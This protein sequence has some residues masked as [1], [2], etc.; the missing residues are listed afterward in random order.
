MATPGAVRSTAPTLENAATKSAPSCPYGPRRSPGSSADGGK[1]P[2]RPRAETA[3]TSARSAGKLTGPRPSLPAAAT[4]TTPASCGLLDGGAH[5]PD[6]ASP[7]PR[8]RLTM[9]HPSATAASRAFAIAKLVASAAAAAEDPV[10]AAARPRERRPAARRWAAS[11][12]DDA[13]HVGAVLVAVGAD[14]RRVLPRDAVPAPGH[15]QVRVVGGDPGVDDRRPARRARP[16][17][18]AVP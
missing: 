14:A 1:V 15:H 5:A 17:A 3:T 8:L 9:S 16:T 18:S 6:P 13:G 7:P 2:V 11:C 10:A 12:G 4:T